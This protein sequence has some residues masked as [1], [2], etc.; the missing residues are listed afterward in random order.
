MTRGL[1]PAR[2][3]S[4]HLPALVANSGAIEM[5]KRWQGGPALHSF[6]NATPAAYVQAVFRGL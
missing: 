2:A 3:S 1:L 5:R 6:S 4:A